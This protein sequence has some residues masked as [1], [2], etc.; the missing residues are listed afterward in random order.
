[1]ALSARD[2]QHAARA[3]VS[4]LSPL[5]VPC[6]LAGSA[7]CFELGNSR[8]P[9]DVDILTPTSLAPPERNP[10][11]T[12]R[13]L[14]YTLSPASA[15]APTN[16]CRIDIFLPGVISLPPV[17]PA[18]VVYSPSGLPT[19]PL[20]SALM[21]KVL[22]WIAHGEAGRIDKQLNDVTDISGLLAV[23]ETQLDSILAE[24]KN[25]YPG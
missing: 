6:C 3:T 17:P 12:Y 5:Q 23:V 1:M 7:A 19:M 13:V 14:W 21:H 9:N 16:K 25:W 22:A 4:A 15:N 11:A 18:F 8:V 20:L 10:L 24:D 2:I